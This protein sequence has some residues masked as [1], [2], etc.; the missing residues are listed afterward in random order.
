MSQEHSASEE[1]Q[2][3][4][5][6]ENA[7]SC[8]FFRVEY[9]LRRQN[10]SILHDHGYQLEGPQIVEEEQVCHSLHDVVELAALTEVDR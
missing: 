7:A 5:R 3:Q 9:I 1:Q 4:N 8:R 6:S 2:G 10:E